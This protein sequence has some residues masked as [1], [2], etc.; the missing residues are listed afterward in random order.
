[1]AVAVESAYRAIR[2][3]IVSG[4]YQPGDHLTAQDLAAASGVSRTPVREAMRRLHAEGLIRVIPNRGAFVASLDETDI[5]KIYD[6][7]VVL[8]GYAAEAASRSADDRQIEALQALADQLGEMVSDPATLDLDLVAANNN[9]FHRLL[10]AA[11]DNARLETA[12][13]SIVEAP[14]VLRTFR[15]YSLEELQRSASQHRELV[16]ALRAHDG[17]WARS[18]M[19]SHILAGR[20]AL[21]KSLEPPPG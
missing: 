20:D 1:M 12:L 11:A 18:V 15:R 6:L 2:D 5:H 19:T 13:A 4:V 21:L 3:G 10:V 16:K 8:E 7:R 17:L 14:L 9:S